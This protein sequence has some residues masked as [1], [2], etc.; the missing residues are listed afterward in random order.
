MKKLLSATLAIAMGAT[1]VWSLAACNT[2][3]DEKDAETAQSAVDYVKQI[4][5]KLDYA[6]TTGSYTLP[7][8]TSVEGNLY[9]VSWTVSTESTSV[10]NITDYIKIGTELDEDYLIT[11]DVTRP[12]ADVE[13]TLTCT[14]KVGN[15]SKSGTITRTLKGLPAASVLT[16]AQVIALKNDASSFIDITSG[17]Y[18]NKYYS[19]DGTSAA[20][21]TVKGYVTTPCEYKSQYKNYENAYIADDASATKANSLQVYRIKADGVYL[22]EDGSTNL[23]NGDLVTFTGCVQLY[24]GNVE[25]TYQ[26][27]NDVKVIALE[28][29]PEKNN[30]EL[31][32]AAADKVAINADLTSK[33]VVTLPSKQDD[34]TLTWA[35]KS[36]GATLAA[37]GYTLTCPENTADTP[38]DVVLTVTATINGTPASKDITVQVAKVAT[39]AEG[40]YKMSLVQGNISGTPKLYFKGTINSS[41]FGETVTDVANAADVAVSNANGGYYLKVG[42]KYLEL[43]TSHRLALVDTPTSVWVYN[44]Q[45]TTF[46]WY[47]ANENE[48]YYLGTYNEFTTIS[49]SK[50]SYITSDTNYHVTLAVESDERTPAQ[51]GQAALDALTIPTNVTRDLELTSSINGVTLSIKA[52]SNT[53]AIA[54]DGTVTRG[55]EDATGITLTIAASIDGTEVAT[56]DFENITVKAGENLNPEDTQEITLSFATTDARESWDNNGQ[57]WK[58]GGITFTNSKAAS[59]SNVVDS[60]NP[61]KCYASSA[62]KIECTGMTQIVFNCNTNAYASDLNNSIGTLTDATV[63]YTA[64]TKVVTVTFDSKCNSFDIAKLTKQVR[65]DSI[66]VT[67]VKTAA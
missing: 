41:N 56:K 60:S 64:N 6:N 42:E 30:S 18:T 62:I 45:Y 15:V 13:Y 51:I 40:T 34:A 19:T 57:I 47:V 23:K 49:A 39:F 48:T 36:G 32:Q 27:N 1:C 63:S 20:V 37:D 29:A 9:D 58:S 10:N 5:D 61:V 52:S 22:K 67:A 21:I 65:I 8:K 26:G 31:A 14:V 25:I 7:G 24:N 2:G 46:T 12:E 59:T 3:N 35:V 33:L 54:L 38:V 66:V 55:S 44:T 17:S 53:A 16:V 50:M 43:N 4:Y 11:V 28:K